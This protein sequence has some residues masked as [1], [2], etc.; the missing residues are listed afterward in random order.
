MTV[1]E[2]LYL[3]I[4]GLPES[5]Q[6]EAL[7]YVESLKQTLANKTKSIQNETPQ[8]TLLNIMLDSQK[9]G[10]AFDDMDVLAWQKQQRQDKPLA[11]RDDV[12]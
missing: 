8:Q 7:R 2:Q 4:Q 9:Q 1:A 3:E 6:V 10:T 5:M 11:Y 12:L